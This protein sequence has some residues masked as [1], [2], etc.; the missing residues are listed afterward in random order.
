M[1]LFIEC[2][3][4]IFVFLFISASAFAQSNESK[5]IP[6]EGGRY[7]SCGHDD[8]GLDCGS[9]LFIPN[10]LVLDTNMQGNSAISKGGCTPRPY[11]QLIV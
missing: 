11:R 8:N 6:S 5:E 10:K 2:S 4:A 3:I 1:K 7:V 9:W